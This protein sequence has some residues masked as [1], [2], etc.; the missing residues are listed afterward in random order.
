MFSYQGVQPLMCH[1]QEAMRKVQERQQH[2]LQVQIKSPS[3]HHAQLRQT[4]QTL[5]KIYRI[6]Q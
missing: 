1:V 5:K 4:S 3:F 2:Q 6:L